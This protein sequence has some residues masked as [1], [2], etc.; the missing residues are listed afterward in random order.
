MSSPTKTKPV[1]CLW[2]TDWKSTYPATYLNH[3]GGTW[4]DG[5]QHSKGNFGKPRASIRLTVHI[6]ADLK[7]PE[8]RKYA[9][10][11]WYGIYSREWLSKFR[12]E[13]T[14]NGP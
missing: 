8:A 11:L 1:Y 12:K 4:T 3:P 6:P 13:V 9:H 5:I 2:G 7:G 14:G 10:T